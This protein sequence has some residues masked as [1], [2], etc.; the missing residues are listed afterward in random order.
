M[1]PAPEKPTLR[2]IE[3]YKGPPLPRLQSSPLMANSSCRRSSYRGR[4]FS[5][6]GLA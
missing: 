3:G 6:H 4:K 5:R 2:V 1:K